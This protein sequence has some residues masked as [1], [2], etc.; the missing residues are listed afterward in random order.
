MTP[1]EKK[2][3]FELLSSRLV[4]Q[5]SVAGIWIICYRYRATEAEE[6]AYYKAGLSEI[7]P[8][9]T[10]TMHMLGLAKD[11]A[12]AAADWSGYDWGTIAAYTKMGEIAESLGLLWGGRWTTLR[13]YGHVQYV[14]GT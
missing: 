8:T 4:E 13:D 10:P 14:E 6:L 2:A 11:F 1:T 3:H 7:D 12:V 9:K 5:C